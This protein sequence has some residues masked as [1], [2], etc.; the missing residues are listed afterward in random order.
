[1]RAGCDVICEKPLVVM[2]KNIAPLQDA[3]DEFDRS[4]H[5]VHQLRF[6]PQMNTL[7]D[8]EE[9]KPHDPANPADVVLTYCAPRGPWYE[10]SWK[11][12]P[13][14]SGG[15]IMN[16]GIH[17]L[18]ALIWIYGPVVSQATYLHTPTR[19][20]GVINLRRA[21]VR[22]LLSTEDRDCEGGRPNRSMTV[23]GRPAFDFSR[24]FGD[25]HQA[26]YE[27]AID[28]D[29]YSVRPDDAAHALELAHRI[30]TQPGAIK[31][32]PDEAHPDL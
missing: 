32:D 7:K 25:L 15:I 5:V 10:R 27:A 24:K 13:N 3:E 30:R 31:Y 26:V 18:D 12:D 29:I 9:A 20:S 21:V 19:M 17:F 8:S 28:G 6:H 22:W 23:D 2:P 14:R 1:M 16:L 11:G 4:I